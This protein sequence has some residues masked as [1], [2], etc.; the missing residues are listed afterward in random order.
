MSGIAQRA[1]AKITKIVLTSNKH[2]ALLNFEAEISFVAN[3]RDAKIVV[4]GI[5]NK[6][7]GLTLD[8]IHHD[9]FAVVRASVAPDHR[10]AG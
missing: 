9:I 1:T 3:A 6:Q 5:I 7:D 2:R 10:Q 8:Q 4:S